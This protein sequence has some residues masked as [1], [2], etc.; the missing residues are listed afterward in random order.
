MTTS[1]NLIDVAATGEADVLREELRA[2]CDGSLY[3]FAKAVMGYK[4]MTD[5]LHL[6][7]C[8]HAQ[9]A[10]IKQGFLVPRGHLKSTIL[11][12]AKVLWKVCRDPE[13]RRLVVGESDTVAAKNLRD[14]KWNILNNQV[15][16]WLYPEVIPPDINN[17]KWTDTEILLPRRGTYD[18]STITTCGVGAKM[19]GFHYTGIDY[20]DIFGE[21]AARS[22]AEAERVREWVQYAPGLLVD[23]EKSEETFTGTRWK[24]GVGDIYGWVM[25]FM[26]YV[27]WY[28]RSAIENGKPIWPERFSLERLEEIRKREGEYKFACQYMN[29]PTPPEGADFAPSWVK[30]YTVSEDKRTIIPEDGTPP[31]SVGQLYRCSMY[32]PSS[33]G[34]TATAENAI[35]VLGQASD[36]RKFVLEEWGK[37][38]DYGTAIER[39]H[40]MKDRLITHD[41]YFEAVGAQKEIANLVRLRRMMQ[42]CAACGKIHKYLSPKPVLPEGGRNKE[43]RIRLYAQDDFAAGRVYL[44]RGMETLRNQI[45]QFPHG[46]LVDRF[47]ALAYAIKLARL[48]VSDEYLMDE[49]QRR[50][51]L[52][53]RRMQRTD[54]DVNYGGYI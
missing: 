44:R 52:A 9:E 3:F 12:K 36:R 48:P 5:D 19:T 22:E 20:D 24:H 54:T 6:D 29:D 32:D 27:S 17:T 26:P 53:A 47:D 41:D 40:I 25:E 34:K 2:R 18:E 38:C 14:L 15:L 50:E 23:P 37:N 49:K 10:Q 28:R 35:I 30:Y 46:T 1:P 16:R 31:I 13:E 51:H 21:I 42:M 43:D 8:T 45:I 4:D 33:G 11:T 39:W 7:M